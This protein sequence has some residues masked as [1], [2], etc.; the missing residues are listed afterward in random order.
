MEALQADLE[1]LESK[2]REGII[3]RGQ[4]DSFRSARISRE[5]NAGHDRITSE[6]SLKGIH[7]F[8]LLFYCVS[9]IV[10]WDYLFHYLC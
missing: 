4:F 1:V 7:I 2:L 3:D 10:W 8:L 6:P 5:I 9:I